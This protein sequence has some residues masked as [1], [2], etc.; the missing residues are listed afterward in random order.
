LAGNLNLTNVGGG[1]IR[2][3]Y[4]DHN[5]QESFDFVLQQCRQQDVKFIRLWFTDIL[6]SLKS[7]AI[8][9]EELEEALEEGVGFDGGAIAG[10][11]RSGESD[12]TAIPDPATF[13]VLPWRPRERRV[14]RMFCD[15]HLPD[16]APF[17]GDPRQVLKRNLERAAALGFTFYVGPE[18][19]YF[20]FKDAEGTTPLDKGGYFDLT[21][22][23][24]A[25]D[26]RRET[27][28][29]L[30][31]MGIGVESSHHEV[32]PSQH[33]VD[34]RYTDAL[35]MADSVLTCRLVV[36]EVA[37]AAG[38]YATFMP[39]PLANENGS[40]M[41][42]HLSLFR[43]EQNAFFAPDDPLHLSAVARGFLAG[44]L[45]HAG[46]I[47]L[48]TNQWVNSYKRLIPGFE[49]PV[50]VAWSPRNF[51]AP[52]TMPQAQAAGRM[53]GD[54][55]RVPEYRQGRELASR[56]E[57]RAPDAACNPYLAFAAILAAGLE[58]IEKEYPLPPSRD[59]MDQAN[60]EQADTLPDS[61]YEAL[62]QAEQS[63][64]LRRCLGDHVFESLL[65]SKRIEWERYRSHITDY[66]LQE[67]LP[68]L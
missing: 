34:L 21:P 35:T 30:E 31:E 5:M 25:S 28:L 15:V 29:T 27:V 61:L 57:Y 11:A 55:L 33:E 26:L 43:G 9:F 36:K 58:G 48:V 6:G 2:S 59:A 19:E 4:Y 62:L 7:F 65:T 49:A 40:G 1:Q 32:A 56:V 24:V 16:G 67:Y 22:L 64:V 10:F 39:K 46:E 54:L 14:A 44:L 45:R 23:D 63:D 41:H 68:I 12:M 17:A 53:P 37:M 42:V 38:V 3:R 51:T 18:V 60:I 52:A 66:E 8:T 20:Y 13:Q 50:R 47:T